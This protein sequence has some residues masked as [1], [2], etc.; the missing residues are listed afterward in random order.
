MSRPGRGGLRW[1]Q[2]R[3]VWVLLAV[4]PGASVVAVWLTRRMLATGASELTA[5][6]I[7]VTAVLAAV[8][9]VLLD[10][11]VVRPLRAIRATEDDLVRMSKAIESSGDAIGL[12]DMA[13]M[14]IHNNPAFVA[15]FGYTVAE[16]N[17]VGGPR[18]LFIDV[19]LGA[20]VFAALGE[21]RSW[22]GEADLRTR[23]GRVVPTLLRADCI[24]DEA[25]N[26]LGMVG[27]AT[28]ISAR[29]RAE[30]ELARARD[31]AL[32][33]ARLKSE[34]LANMSHEIRTPMNVIFGMTDLLLETARTDE[35]RDYTATVRRSAESL[36]TVIDDVLDLSKIEA[37]RLELEA[38]DFDLDAVLD[39]ALVVLAPR[40]AAKELELC[41]L[42]G[43][44]VPRAVVG[45][46]GR[47]RQILVNLIGNAVKFTERGEV[48]LR[49]GLIGRS[50]THATLRFAITDS[51]IGIPTERMHRLFESFSQV[52]GSMSRRYGGTGLGLAISKQLAEMM[53]GEVGVE[54]EAGR[55]STFWFT[56]RL[57]I[58]AGE[59]AR[60]RAAPAGLAGAGGLVVD[61]SATGRAV[62]SAQ[63]A[64]LAIRPATAMSAADGL[65]QLRAA[66]RA[67]TPIDVVLIAVGLSDMTPAELARA[68]RQEPAIAGAR[69]VLLAPLGRS[70][71]AGPFD[72]RLT[73]PVR[74]AQLAACLGHLLAEAGAGASR[75]SAG[76]EAEATPSGS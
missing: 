42:V 19:A 24:V 11:M 54:S 13:G 5:I 27:V 4:G 66:A 69:C 31:A 21:G 9:Y 6:P 46:P 39:D 7:L 52:D 2:L 50:Q 64:G 68:I 47:L 73:K 48:V 44:S 72:A 59:L 33:S 37:G 45:D 32:E 29:R 8:G 22:S 75:S 38:L 10:R 18:A 53:G 41:C 60:T 57:E 35:Q 25:G 62:L 12:A 63:L 14:S 65:R 16:L 71:G 28:D 23:A 1:L 67:G 20:E 3:I 56:A 40:A 26:R 70:A 15:L 43:P 74:E 36:L 34:F 51:G 49:V 58:G 17:V 55:G 61:V 76:V 30:G